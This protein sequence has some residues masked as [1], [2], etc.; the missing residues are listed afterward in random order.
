MHSMFTEHYVINLEINY[1]KISGKPTIIWKLN[2]TYM[3]HGLKEIKEKIKCRVNKIVTKFV[4][5]S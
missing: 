4:G 3:T 1:G 5:C 2:N